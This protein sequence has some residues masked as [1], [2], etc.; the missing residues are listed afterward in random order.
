[1]RL[2]RDPRYLLLRLY[3]P[4][5]R[6]NNGIDKLS[7]VSNMER[8]VGGDS[9]LS[10][11]K[12]PTSTFLRVRFDSAGDPV[13]DRQCMH[14]SSEREGRTEMLAPLP[15]LSY[16]LPLACRNAWAE[17]LADGAVFHTIRSLGEFYAELGYTGEAAKLGQL[18]EE[19][20]WN[21]Y[22]RVGADK[23]EQ[24]LQTHIATYLQRCSPRFRDEY[25]RK[26]E[27]MV[28]RCLSDKIDV[29]DFCIDCPKHPLHCY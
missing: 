29:S 27:D 16:R 24:C 4:Q 7:G 25:G 1:M 5:R 20:I 28:G 26:F 10:C 2:A 23:S 21:R 15:R 3:F 17:I 12:M 9:L 22:R 18:P 6:A 11:R 8:E 14:L 13:M 19:Y